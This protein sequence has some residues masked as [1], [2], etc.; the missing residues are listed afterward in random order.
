MALSEEI[1]WS[2][3]LSLRT[4]LGEEIKKDWLAALPSLPV[5]GSPV[6]SGKSMM[7]EE[8]AR[9]LGKEIIRGKEIS[10]VWLDDLVINA[11]SL[12]DTFRWQTAPKK[13]V[14][15]F[16]DPAWPIA[17]VEVFCEPL[18]PGH[19]RHPNPKGS[20]IDE[21]VIW[22]GGRRSR[23]ERNK[24]AALINAQEMHKRLVAGLE[25]DAQRELEEARSA[26]N[27]ARF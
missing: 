10:T 8:Y 4:G 24:R 18:E 9:K 16:N 21:F 11:D 15:S 3:W 7:L 20:A 25:L 13:P 19:P 2:A 1:D 14:A 6:R 23:P 27:Y 22:A 12:G 17:K 26:P 5:F